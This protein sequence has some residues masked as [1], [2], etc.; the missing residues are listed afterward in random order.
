[1]KWQHIL[2]L[3]L[4]TFLFSFNLP[5]GKLILQ[6]TSPLMMQTLKSMTSAIFIAPFLRKLPR[7]SLVDAFVMALLLFSVCHSL[8]SMAIKSSSNLNLMAFIN[9]LES[10]LAAIFGLILLAEQLSKGKIIGLILAIL[11][12]WIACRP[13]FASESQAMALMLLSILCGAL[14]KL[15]LRKRVLKECP[16]QF[17]LWAFFFSSLQFAGGAFLFDDFVLPRTFGIYVGTA[18]MGLTGLIYF[19]IWS[20][21]QKAYSLSRLS[22]FSLL[23]LFTLPGANY[24]V[25]D[26]KMSGNDVFACVILFVSLCF[27]INTANSKKQVSYS[28]R[29]SRQPS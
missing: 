19:V 18:S 29:P 10:P 16:T 21:L 14:G 6:N 17:M 2:L 13:Q 8:S 5:I 22:P 3:F 26:Q 24:L 20:H 4:A 15:L 27:L 25:L 28:T 12:L 23:T 1:M 7:R 9:M 11:A